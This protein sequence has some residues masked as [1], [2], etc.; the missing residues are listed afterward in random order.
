MSYV[1]LPRVPQSVIG[2]QPSGTGGGGGGVT[3]QSI[4]LGLHAPHQAYSCLIR[5][6][7]NYSELRYTAILHAP[8]G[9]CAFLSQTPPTMLVWCTAPPPLS[10]GLAY[11]TERPTAS[12][13]TSAVIHT[14]PPLSCSPHLKSYCV[15]SAVIRTHPPLSCSPHLKSYCVTSAVIRTHPPL[16]LTHTRDGS[17]PP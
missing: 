6:I 17:T 10:T 13:V 14:H 3:K 16:S 15:T 9:A 5:G 2:V 7:R 4:C 8:P 11:S 1:A 12:F